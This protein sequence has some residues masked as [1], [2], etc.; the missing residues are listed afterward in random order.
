MTS[1]RLRCGC[2]MAV[3]LGL[4]GAVLG[5]PSTGIQPDQIGPSTTPQASKDDKLG[6]VMDLDMYAP[7]TAARELCGGFKFT[8]GPV[9]VPASEGHPRGYLLFSD[10][11]ADTIQKWT[12]AEGESPAVGTVEVFRNPSR[13]ANG[14]V[15]D[16]EG[17]LVVCEHDRRL[18]RTEKDGTITSLAEKHNGLR[19]NSPNDVC[20][21][22]DGAIYF[23]DPPYGMRPPL[24]PRMEKR[25]LSFSGVF[26]VNNDGTL[27]L[28]VSDMP[29]P[30]GI[31]F[32]PDEKLL[33]VSDTGVGHIKVFEIDEKGLVKPGSGKVFAEV[34]NPSMQPD[35]PPSTAGPD[36]L[37]VDVNGNVYCAAAGGVWVFAPSG[38]QLGTLSTP[39]GAANLCFGDADHKALYVTC[40]SS[41]YRI[42]LKVAGCP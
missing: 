42:P 26:R 24:G 23:T 16:K 25:E 38:E 34:K 28:L 8:E 30:N 3:S 32:S 11:P 15:F 29:S 35:Q 39:R 36:G 21:K 14:L 40:R 41:V 6:A 31:A 13:F 2:S 5:Q 37:K 22:S 27:D 18:S 7:K 19:L 10:I 4:A 12:P 1:S 33:Y 20:I 17:R 9:W